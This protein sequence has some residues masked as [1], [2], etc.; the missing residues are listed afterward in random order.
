MPRARLD[1]PADRSGAYFYSLCVALDPVELRQPSD[2]GRRA[3]LPEADWRS[4]TGLDTSSG[5]GTVCGYLVHIL[6][7][8]KQGSEPAPVFESLFQRKFST[9]LEQ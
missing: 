8:K 7:A 1:A 9:T 3:I 2:R 4:L 5:S 6:Q